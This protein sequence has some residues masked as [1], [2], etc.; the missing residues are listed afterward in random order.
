[1][2]ESNQPSTH[3][4]RILLLGRRKAGKTVYLSRLYTLAWRGVTGLHMRA[5]EG[6]MHERCMETSEL[7]GKGEWPAA[8]SGS[9]MSQV[10]ITWQGRTHQMM[11]LD[12]PGEVFREAFVQGAEGGQAAA[13]RDHVDRAAGV[14]LLIDPGNVQEG[15]T[16]ELIDDDYGMV[17][18]LRYLRQSPGGEKIPVAV[19][20]TKCDEH[21]G[22][23]RR[24][25]SARQF[26]EATLPNLI[27]YGGRMR[28]YATSAVRTRPDALGRATPNTQHPPAGLMD[29]LLYCLN[30]AAEPPQD[31]TPQI[32]RS[33]EEPPTQPMQAPKHEV[34]VTHQRW[35]LFWAAL[36]A[37]AI[38]VIA[39]SLV[40]AFSDATDPNQTAPALPDSPVPINDSRDDS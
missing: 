21:V 10:E 31:Q 28:I 33:I 5:A 26:I 24:H 32:S 18:A 20:L 23:I 6:A 15:S 1:M 4:D 25:G 27:R 3:R 19:A 36:A 29:P 35:I 9:I 11:M 7:L 34:H 13:L 40:I 39:A 16:S 14:V 12:Y 8:T 17:Q 38:C 30:H 37:F 22:M 2:T